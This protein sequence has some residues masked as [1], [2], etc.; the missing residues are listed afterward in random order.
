MKSY[1]K[2]LWYNAPTR[3]AFI[4]ITSQIRECLTESGV[5]EGWC[6]STP[7]ILLPACL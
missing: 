5:R 2:E 1:R 6:W 4:N 3:V 7:C